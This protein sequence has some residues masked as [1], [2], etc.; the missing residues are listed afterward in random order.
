LANSSQ[1]ELLLSTIAVLYQPSDPLNPVSIGGEQLASILRQPLNVGQGPG[2]LIATS[3]RDQLEVHFFPNKIDVRELSGNIAQGVR[4]IPEILY[5]FLPILGQVKIQSYGINL[6]LETNVE[7]P[8][9]WLGDKFLDRQLSSTLGASPSCDV[10]V[11][12][13]EGPPKE[14]KFQFAAQPGDKLNV[15]FNASERTDALP[16]SSRLGEELSEQYLAL[17]ELLAQLGL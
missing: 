9:R 3:S 1:A 7:K 13:L 16:S 10:I 14:R 2:L 15:N 12:G 11:L 6:V 5:K 4:K 8:N 17:I